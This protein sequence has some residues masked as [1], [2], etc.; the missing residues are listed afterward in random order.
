MRP[1][2]SMLK[3]LRNKL[4]IKITIGENEKIDLLIERNWFTGRFIFTANG[5][6]HTLRSPYSLF[7]HFNV[8][9]KNEYNFEVGKTEKHSVVIQH[10]RPRFFAGFRDQE[11][12]LIVDG[13]LIE[14][15]NG[16]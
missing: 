3:T 2:K 7:T 12:N 11:F 8:R 10:I 16:Y 14:S 4:E 13:K 6:K 9:T 1:L 15:S 5:E